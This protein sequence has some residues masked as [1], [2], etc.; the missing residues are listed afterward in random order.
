MTMC[1]IGIMAWLTCVG[2]SYIVYWI[3]SRRVLEHLKL[4]TELK[5]LRLLVWI[6][7]ELSIMG[8]SG[9]LGMMGGFL[10]IEGGMDLFMGG[11]DW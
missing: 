5:G 11:E 9:L 7:F 10:A 6:G 3:G 1:S 2:A 8:G 4:R